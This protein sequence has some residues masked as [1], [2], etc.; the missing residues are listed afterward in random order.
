MVIIMSKTHKHIYSK[1]SRDAALLLG[2]YIQ[3]ARKEKKMTA[4]DM[5]SRAG[6]SRG[7][8]YKI[9]HG[10]LHCELGIVFEV[11]AIAGILLFEMSS[12][13]LS[14]QVANME[15]KLHLLPKRIQVSKDFDDN[16]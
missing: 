8:L 4:A 15:S 14:M 13:N 9:E 10:N 6:I 12:V 1:Y 3:A 16:F 11:A 5:A 7:T 2:L